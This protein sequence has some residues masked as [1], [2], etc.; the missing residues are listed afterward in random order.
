[1][2][3]DVL[4]GDMILVSL[5]QE[6]M[7]RYDLDFG[8]QADAAVT[9]RGLTRLMY[10]VGEQCG[11][12]HRDKS[13]LIEALPGRDGCLLIISVRVAHRRRSYRVKRVERRCVCRFD[14][15]DDMLDLFEREDALDGMGYRLYTMD[16]SYYLVPEVPPGERHR[17]LLSEYGCLYDERT[18]T[19][20]RLCEYGRL[21]RHSRTH[22]P[23]S[24]HSCMAAR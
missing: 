20:A 5:L 16:G 6:D 10:R 19:L 21:I 23:Y 2:T 3:I 24:R 4:G 12:D 13:Y 9:R 22:C 14:S 11:L 8:T 18:V 1:M 15:T 7:R 17:V